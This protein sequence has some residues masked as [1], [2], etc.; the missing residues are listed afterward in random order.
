V[1]P[2]QKQPKKK[3]ASA[4]MN[5]FIS[6]SSEEHRKVRAVAATA[7]SGEAHEYINMSVFG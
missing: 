4:A 1:Q 3:K 2:E 7:L 5:F 6:P